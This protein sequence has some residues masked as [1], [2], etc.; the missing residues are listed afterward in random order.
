M[1]PI[2]DWS[3]EDTAEFIE[4]ARKLTKDHVW[5]VGDWAM[6]KS[7]ILDLP[8]EIN[9]VMSHYHLGS[10]SFQIPIGRS[11]IYDVPYN[12]CTWLPL[13]GDLMDLPEWGKNS[14]NKTQS[15]LWTVF[16]ILANI[17][18]HEHRLMAMIRAVTE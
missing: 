8:D 10:L 6:L 5:K 13:E 17:A 11:Q 14:V 12:V 7:Q 15:G 1:H 18:E 4:R 9:I 16:K 3:D 2:A